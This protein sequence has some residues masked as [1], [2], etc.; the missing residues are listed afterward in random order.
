MVLFQNRPH[1]IQSRQDGSGY[2]YRDFFMVF[3][4]LVK[5]FYSQVLEK[6]RCLVFVFP[7]DSDIIFN[8]VVL[9]LR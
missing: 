3:L 4:V 6:I 8:M 7:N 5:F 2:E 9:L 1:T